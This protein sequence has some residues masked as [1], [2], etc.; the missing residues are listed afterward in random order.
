ML[1]DLF[2]S[3]DLRRVISPAVVSDNTA[4]VGQV[5]DMINFGSVVFCIATG[6]LAD[7]DATF[8]TLLEESSDNSTFATVAAADLIGTAAL[9]S[10]TFTND[11]AVR[12]LGY[13]G[14]K[15]YV[16]LTITPAANT[17]SAPI[18]AV[19]ILGHARNQPRS[20]QS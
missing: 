18:G 16:R 9:A 12:K 6:T 5:I 19:A 17:G 20:S 2:N 4:A 11:D 1:R 14:S 3:L 8:T 15:R 10:F 13:I 7:A